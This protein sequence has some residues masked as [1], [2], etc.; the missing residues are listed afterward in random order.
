MKNPLLA[1]L[2]SYLGNHQFLSLAGN[3]TVSAMSIVSVS[4]LFRA[5][6][7]R[8]IGVWVLF[9]SAVGLADSFRTGF[10]TT[11]FIRA[12]SGATPARTAE[13]TG[14]AWAI[15]LAIT[16]ALVVLNL[17]AW[18]LLGPTADGATA[19]LLR[20][21]GV[22]LVV[23]LPYFMAASVMQSDMRFDRILYIRLLSQGLFVLS[24]IGL[25]LSGHVTLANVVYG[26][27]GASVVT[28]LL[29]LL[30]GWAQLGTLGHRSRACVSELAHFGKYSVGSYV[31]SNLL[32]SSDTFVINYMLGPAPL[33]VYNLAG[34][35]MEIVEIPLRSFVAT[36][37]PA[38]S[39]AF[40]QGRPHGVVHL[41]RKNAG[42]LTWL[43][44]PV[45]LGTILL[46]DL[47]IYLI[48]G[49]KY[50]GTEAANLLRIS[51]V[52]T[53]LYP[54]DRFV[55]I[56]LDV[57]NQPRL[58]MVKVFLML[59]VNVT[60]DVTALLLFG[61]IYG[62]A[63][64]SLPTGIAGFTFGY[65]HLKKYLPV[66]IRGI[67]TTGLSE[68]RLLAGRFFSKAAVVLKPSQELP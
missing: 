25:M 58:N 56:T 33:A 17:G 55:G 5:L 48:G 27:V 28:S 52:L 61:N 31:G 29:M 44:V 21:F 24:V 47:P 22:V 59:A 14:S 43:F 68:L 9:M 64:A 16:G 36:A 20:W 18:L 37:M 3:L 10:L 23:T 38:M 50:Q 45:I 13:V 42:M 8:E 41:L 66:S 40:N 6:P 15:A 30:L 19:L 11:A 65:L 54:I 26:Y 67:L 32:R 60:G 1:K 53:V 39:A 49:P 51:M 4:L 63:V 7:V 35:F 2:Q 57:V 12:R 46:A 62:V 34:R